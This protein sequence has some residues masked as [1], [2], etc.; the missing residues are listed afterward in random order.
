MA[1]FSHPEPLR[2]NDSER[3]SKST[4]SRWLTRLWGLPQEEARETPGAHFRPTTEAS[5]V[6]R[7]HHPEACHLWSRRNSF[8]RS[9]Q[10]RLRLSSYHANPVCWKF[11]NVQEKTFGVNKISILAL[12]AVRVN[13][14]IDCK[15]KALK[16]LELIRRLPGA[17]LCQGQ[18]FWKSSYR[19]I[20]KFSNFQIHRKFISLSHSA[21]GLD[22]S[23]VVTSIDSL[24]TGILM[25]VVFVVALVL[26]GKSTN[27]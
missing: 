23:V 12:L 15:I 24:N 19:K 21:P 11:F 16:W 9:L 5:V 3:Q 25:M 20:F 22:N 18:Y 6:Q 26:L 4:C 7:S 8:T 10:V 14:K 13:D 2:R 27:L 17:T 1:L